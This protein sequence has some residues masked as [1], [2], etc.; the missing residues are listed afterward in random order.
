MHAGEIIILVALTA[1]AVAVLGWIY[2]RDRRRLTAQRG[3]LFAHCLDLLE[4]PRLRQK[5]LDYPVLTGRYRGHAVHLDAVIDHIALRKVPSLWLRVSLLT[6]LPGM[7]TLD[8]LMRA[9]NVEFFS[10]S[11]E[12]PHRLD[13]PVGWPTEAMIR[14]DAP[15]RLPPAELLTPHLAFFERPQAKEILIAPK[16]LRL[17]FQ[18][19]QADRLH[20]QVLRQ[21]DFA[22]PV[23]SPDLVRDLLDRLVA[24]QDDLS[25]RGGDAGGTTDLIA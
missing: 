17:V 7:A 9:Q 19:S 1:L 14:T 12:L 4:A 3:A 25:R 23:L 20:Y 5:D 16:G 2:R 24:L 13:T 6:P 15:D 8:I 10:P 21:A 11:D 22:S 18:A